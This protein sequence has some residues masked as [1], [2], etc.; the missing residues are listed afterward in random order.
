MQGL[1]VLAYM[2]SDVTVKY[3]THLG[4][5]NSDSNSISI[6]NGMA[7]LIVLFDGLY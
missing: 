7:G 4:D 3:F 1:H 5:S 2:C 6:G